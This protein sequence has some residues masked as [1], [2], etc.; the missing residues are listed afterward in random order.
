MDILVGSF[1]E[2]F[3]KVQATFGQDFSKECKQPNYQ[4]TLFYFDLIFLILL[5]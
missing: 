1:A 4:G 5:Y 2:N 3:L